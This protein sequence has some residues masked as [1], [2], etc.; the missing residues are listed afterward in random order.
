MRIDPP[1]PFRVP[2]AAIPA[3]GRFLPPFRFGE[4]Y[5]AYCRRVGRWFGRRRD[6][7]NR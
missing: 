6:G 3:A 5:A 2:I 1:T 7:G 4:R